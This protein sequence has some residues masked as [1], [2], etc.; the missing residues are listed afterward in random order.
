MLSFV[1]RRV[2][3]GIKNHAAAPINIAL[4]AAVLAISPLAAAQS[5]FQGDWQYKQSCGAEHSAELH[6]KQSGNNVTGE[7]SDGSARGDG[8]SGSLQGVL[9][10]QRLNVAYCNDDASRKTEDAVCP[11]FNHARSD[12][13]VLRGDNLDWYQR[14][15]KNGHPY[16]TLHRVIRGN[17]TPVDTQCADDQ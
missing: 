6:L 16:L 9:E 2:D 15:D 17:R 8:D 7:W 5:T 14:A 4:F 1:N 13:Y 10:N 11:V 3:S 12:Y